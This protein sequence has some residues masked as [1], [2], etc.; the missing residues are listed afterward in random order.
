[1]KQH[2][3]KRILA[4]AIQVFGWGIL[5]GMPLFTTDSSH[6]LT[7]ERF[8]NFCIMPLSCMGIFYLN[9]LWLIDRLLFHK[10]TFSFIL[11]N[12]ILITAVVVLLQV[13][14]EYQMAQDMAKG[15]RPP[16]GHLPRPPKAIF[17]L[18]DITL[19]GLTAALSTAVKMTGQWFRMESEKKALE[20]ARTEAELT[21]LKNQLNPHFLFN[22]LNNIYALIGINP[23]KAQYAV[24]SLSR[25]LRHI[26]YDNNQN[27]VPIEKEFSF[28]KSYIELMSLRLPEQ[29][30]LE[31]HIPENGEGISV[32]PLLFIS[33][34]EN[35]FK[36]GV[37]HRNDSFIRI[38]IEIK[39][40]K[41]VICTVE[42]SY[43][44]KTDLDRTG[45][46]IGVQNL[47]QRLPLIYPDRYTFRT[48]KISNTYFAQ[49]I[50][51]L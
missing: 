13:I 9:Y 24:D 22:T 34:I 51:N 6:T 29:V 10:K 4:I 35:A 3:H 8:L 16:D 7:L 5:L 49:L 44:P 33:L 15:I 25:L 18:R 21:N 11:V 1:M 30:R 50:I 47:Q 37:S 46:G 27:T 32:A 23:E 26:L 20:T 2:N 39:D 42:N 40:R 17:V 14:Q 19:L 43:Y 36:H 31:V 41:M 45:S 48:E 28:M 38:G 12:I